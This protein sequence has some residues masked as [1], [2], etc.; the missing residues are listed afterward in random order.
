[1][2]HRLDRR[3]GYFRHSKR[4]FLYSYFAARFRC[5]KTAG[6]HTSFW[7]VNRGTIDLSTGKQ[8]VHRQEIDICEQDS[9]NNHCLTF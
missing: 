7:T 1:M 6:W 9:A 8:W 4:E 2:D 3:A 5:P